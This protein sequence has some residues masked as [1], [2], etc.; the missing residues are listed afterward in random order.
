MLWF[1]ADI[2]SVYVEN[3]ENFE[4]YCVL[5]FYRCKKSS[6]QKNVA[7]LSELTFAISKFEFKFSS[8]YPLSNVMLARLCVMF[9]FFSCSIPIILICTVLFRFEFLASIKT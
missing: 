7:N 6:S 8:V 4:L 9:Q 3:M 1:L 5:G 2:Y